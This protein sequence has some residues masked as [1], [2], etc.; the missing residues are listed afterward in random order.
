MSGIVWLA[1]YPKSGNT[2]L[3]AFLTNFL[4]ADARPIDIN[5]LTAGI[6]SNRRVF[7]ET[8]GVESSD[9]TRDEIARRRPECYRRMAAAAP[10]TL[11]LKVHDANLPNSAGEPLIPAD[12]T[13]RAVYLV[14]NPLD[15][16]VSFAHH[17]AR[18]VDVAIGS[19]ANPDFAFGAR[20]GLL[21]EQLEQ[22]LSSW[23]G[24]VLSWLDQSRF[25]LHLMR[26]EDML[27]RPALC[28]RECV[29]F[30]GLDED[31]A[32]ID[33]ALSFSS[34]S[35]LRAQ[36]QAFGFRERPEAASSFFRR[37]QAGKWRETL[38]DEQVR[39]IL[40]HHSAVMRR[41]GYLAEDDQNLTI[42]EP[43]QIR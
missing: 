32:A 5:R 17:M 41:L 28:F 37:G 35:A 22:R 12:A 33:R 20:S 14:R 34:F 40:S 18:S 4:G 2:W 6:A 11:Y 38:S 8:L 19:M 16:A 39:L 13:S 43:D 42:G 27:E 26:Y 25:P 31:G 9:M 15:V 21:P 30:L 36:E 29:R 1:S 3:R 10:G 23:S 24:H 7:D